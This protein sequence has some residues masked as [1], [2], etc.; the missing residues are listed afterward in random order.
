M[1]GEMIAQVAANTSRAPY[2]AFAL[3]TA[4]SFYGGTRWIGMH[5]KPEC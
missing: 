5:F 2:W 1:D 3:A 4:V